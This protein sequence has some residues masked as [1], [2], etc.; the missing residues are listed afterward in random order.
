MITIPHTYAQ[1]VELLVQFRDKVDDEN[2]IAAM[3]QG[4]LEWQAGVAERFATRL[5][6]AVNTRMN[7]ATDKLQKEILRSQGQERLIVQ[8][9]LGARKELTLMMKAVNVSVLPEK[10]RLQYHQLVITQADSIQK[11][12]ED[13]ARTDRTGKL[14][15]IIRNHKVNAF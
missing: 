4:S 10:D 15:N 7:V 14:S 3:Q 8:A 5:I 2:V 11:A 9:L 12:L 1:W 13:S 6:D